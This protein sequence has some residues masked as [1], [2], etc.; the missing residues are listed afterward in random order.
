MP[1]GERGVG[2]EEHGEALPGVGDRLGGRVDVRLQQPCQHL[3]RS[4]SVTGIFY[5]PHKL[6]TALHLEY[7]DWRFVAGRRV[8]VQILYAVRMPGC[9]ISVLSLWQSSR[10]GTRGWPFWLAGGGA[11]AAKVGSVWQGT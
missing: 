9:K 6:G 7:F 2:G 3:R 8:G 4:N 5:G 11:D 10:I 1:P